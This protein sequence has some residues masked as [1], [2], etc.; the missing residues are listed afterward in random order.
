[1]DV[2]AGGNTL[3]GAA[4]SQILFG[5]AG[6]DTLNGGGGSDILVGGAGNDT[7]NGDG[8]DDFIY[9]TGALDARDVVNGGTGID[10]FVLQGVPGAET[11]TIYA[12]A[13]AET[14]GFGAGLNLNTEIV[15]TRTVGAGPATVIAELDNIEEIKVNSLLTTQQN[16]NG[17]V[18]GGTTSDGDTVNVVGNF[19]DGLNGPSSLTSL[20]FNTIRVNGTNANDTV[21]ISG[22][23]SD[24]RI[25]FTTNGGA[26]TILGTVRTQD[27]VNG[28]VN[29]LRVAG[30]S[31]GSGDGIAAMVGG[32]VSSPMLGLSASDKASASVDAGT[33][34]GRTMVETGDFALAL[35]DAVDPAPF[36][37]VFVH[38]PAVDLTGGDQRQVITDYPVS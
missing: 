24:H 32:G 17:T 7:V 12:R 23:Q 2:G 21:N 36:V 30:T 4:G 13:A 38:D 26:D 9:M 19:G 11:F 3:A 34:H 10:T 28:S 37:P 25:V 27:I 33:S 6:N 5:R 1:M 8:G 31:F 20:L 16:G 29:D 18:D 22:L 15:I 14:A 35:I